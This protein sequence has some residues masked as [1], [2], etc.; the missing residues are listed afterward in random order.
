MRQVLSITRNLLLVTGVYIA[1]CGM[2]AA[3]AGRR[4]AMFEHVFVTGTGAVIR[5][6]SFAVSVAGQV[7]L[8]GLG[9]L[10]PLMFT[11]ALPEGW[12]ERNLVLPLVPPA[13][14][15][16]PPPDQSVRQS[17]AQPA[18]PRVSGKFAAPAR[19]HALNSVLTAPEAPP[20]LWEHIGSVGVPG[21]IG[22]AGG[23]GFALI[24]ELDRLV[25][26]KPEPSQATVT[27]TA[28]EKPVR[29]RV[30]GDVKPPVPLHT[31]PPQ[32]PL[33]AQRLRVEGIVH[34]EAIIGADGTV[35]NLRYVDGPALLTSAALAAVRQWRYQPP[36]LNGDPVEMEMVVSVIFK[37]R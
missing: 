15:M 31:P 29:V 33:I 14:R 21:G 8:V 34:L 24:P 3:A 36:T 22:L 37:L 28:V 1:D 25:P 23:R 11:D 9:I 16:Q 35:S 30:G 7:A 12:V 6:Y 32:Y 27:K 20:A 10:M 13:I 5:P 19:I 2:K 17:A 18:G 4:R 26:A